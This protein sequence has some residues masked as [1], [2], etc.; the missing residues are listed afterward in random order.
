M[1]FN[2]RWPGMVNIRPNNHS[3]KSQQHLGTQLTCTPYIN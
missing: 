3:A 2:T 1:N